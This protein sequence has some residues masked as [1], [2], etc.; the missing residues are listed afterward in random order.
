MEADAGAVDA[1]EVA[2]G[3]GIAGRAAERPGCAAV[4]VVPPRR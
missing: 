1:A 3:D 4:V 2:V